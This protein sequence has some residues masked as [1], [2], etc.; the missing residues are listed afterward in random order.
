MSLSRAPVGLSCFVPLVAC[1]SVCECESHVRI[2][3]PNCH[4]IR[5]IVYRQP[6]VRAKSITYYPYAIILKF[7][8]SLYSFH[9]LCPYTPTW[10]RQLVTMTTIATFSPQ[11]TRQMA[12]FPNQLR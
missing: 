7:D 2:D 10:I 4:Q 1:R 11:E 8:C 9:F 12:C 5:R 6:D 3:Q